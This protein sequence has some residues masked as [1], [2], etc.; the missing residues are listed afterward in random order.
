MIRKQDQL[1]T[2]S[3][4]LI[5]AKVELSTLMKPQKYSLLVPNLSTL[6]MEQ[7]PDTLSPGLIKLKLYL[8]IL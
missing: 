2:P 3:I 5:M 6:Q 4:S 8:E 1:M 7:R